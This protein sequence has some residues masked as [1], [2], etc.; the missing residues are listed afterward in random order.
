MLVKAF[1]AGELPHLV[2]TRATCDPLALVTD[3]RTAAGDRC[4][5]ARSG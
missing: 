3:L 4:I 2:F 5:W 1:G